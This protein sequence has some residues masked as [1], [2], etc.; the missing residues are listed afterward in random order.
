MSGPSDGVAVAGGVLLDDGED[1]DD[2]RQD[3]RERRAEAEL[4]ERERL[5]VDLG[6]EG[7]G[8]AGRTAA[9]ES[10]DLVEDAQSLDD[11]E[12]RRDRDRRA[13]RRHR[14]GPE[15]LPDVRAVER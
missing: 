12:R 11:A 8:G 10:E 9:R 14:H 7:L 5:L 6:R 1:E 15:A 3:E 4:A 13:D 2:E